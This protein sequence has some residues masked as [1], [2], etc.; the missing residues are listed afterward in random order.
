MSNMYGDMLINVSVIYLS[1]VF[2][3]ET[4]VNFNILAFSINWEYSKY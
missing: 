1:T 4:K 3:I 2:T